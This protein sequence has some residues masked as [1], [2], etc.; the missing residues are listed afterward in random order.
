MKTAL[1]TGIRGQDGAYLARLLLDKGYTVVG[2]DR[3][4]GDSENWRLKE[5]GVFDD[6]QIEYMDLLELT[7]II[8][9]LDKTSPDEVY[10]LAAQSFVATS[11][12]QPVLTSDI[13]A[14]GVLRVLE[15]LRQVNSDA[16]FYQASTSEMFGKVKEEPQNEDTPFHPN[17]PYASL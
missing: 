13:N 3:R 5:L 15:G 17:M 1:I 16:R 11:F 2:A 7:N 6:I 10:N 14:L 4:S 8:R 9:V 12:E